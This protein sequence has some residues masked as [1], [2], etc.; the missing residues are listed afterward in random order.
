MRAGIIVSLE[1]PHIIMTS[2]LSLVDLL[3]YTAAEA[4]GRSIKLLLG[5]MTDS[6]AMHAAIKNASF[7][8]SNTTHAVLYERSGQCRDM[9]VTC[10]PH[11]DPW[12]VLRGCAMMLEELSGRVSSP[13]TT[14]MAIISAQP[15]HAVL[16][17]NEA[18][19]SIFGLCA[20]QVV[21]RT[22]RSV[23][24]P[25][26]DPA[27]WHAMVRSACAGAAASCSLVLRSETPAVAA[28]CCSSLS[29][30]DALAFIVLEA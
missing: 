26:T 14:A 28:S 7:D 23:H 19:S 30:L 29:S 15:P 1:S 17:V 24:G 4:V 6:V 27:R 9:L 8:K 11:R 5:P 25:R 20:A 3:G 10:S 2:D 12:G 21:G 18:F 16:T 22:L 13:S